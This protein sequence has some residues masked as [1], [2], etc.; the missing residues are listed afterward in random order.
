MALFG[1][2]FW[3]I[4]ARLFT[5][6]Q[7]G[8]ASTLI[9]VLGLLVNMSL[10][11]FN[12]ALLKYLPQSNH[13]DEKISSCFILSGLV[14]LVV[15]LIF[16]LGVDLFSPKLSFLKTNRTYFVLFVLFILFGTLFTLIESIF[17]AYRKSKFVLVKNMI[18]SIFK[19]ILPVFLVAWGAFGIFGSWMIAMLIA[20][21]ISLFFVNIDFKLRVNWELLKKMF[22]FSSGNYFANLLAIAPGM[23]LPIMV[24]NLINPTQTAYFYIAWMVASLLFVVPTAVSQSLLTES[25][26]E[27]LGNKVKKAYKIIFLLLG[28]GVLGVLLFGKLI[29]W[30]FGTNYVS[31]AYLSLILLSLSSIP[32][33]LN[34]IF[35]T[36]ENIKHN[37]QKV[38]LMYGLIAGITFVLAYLL[39]SYGL[40]GIS[41][42][43]L[44][45]NLIVALVRRILR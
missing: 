22:K 33:A 34:V 10:L 28:V 31:G 40:V 7:V 16:V 36:L 29:L 41:L 4:N 18:W 23:V 21:I 37:V 44:I 27:E 32:F 19:V 2:V 3:T 30:L 13:R 12:M 24:T 43:W 45:G 11:G 38:V 14:S 5:A 20:L 6:E 15:S 26:H 8:L 25:S 42:S 9:S 35:I 39:L 1:F 17:I